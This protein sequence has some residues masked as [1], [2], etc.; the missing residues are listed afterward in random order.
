MKRRIFVAVNLPD[1]IK[2]K[3]A[4]Y[5]SQ[6]NEIPANWTRKENLHITLMFLGYVD[7]QELPEVLNT[8]KRISEKSNSFSVSIDKV[9]YG[10]PRKN[11]P[12]MIWATGESQELGNLHK[13]LEK[14]LISVK[15]EEI[16]EKSRDQKN[17]THITL[18]RV[19]SW[20]FRKMNPE[21]MPIVDDDVSISFDVNSIEVMESVLK[22]GGPQYLT[23]DSYP[24]A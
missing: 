10:P 1:K 14:D 8:V 24:L 15:D 11:P 23:L 2:E 5:Q 6:W 9:C 22:K 21:E 4:G 18:A 19:K 7:D 20:E 16:E 13:K 17:T 3:L 12:R